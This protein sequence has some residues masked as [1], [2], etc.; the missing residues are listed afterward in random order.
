MAIVKF[1]NRPFS[2]FFPSAV[3]DFFINDMLPF[4]SA[5]TASMPATN[6]EE[7]ENEFNLEIAIPGLS[8]EDINVEIDNNRLVVSS[9]KEESS[10]EE[11]KNYTRKEYSFSSFERAFTLPENATGDVSAR[12]EDGVLIVTLPKKKVE[13]AKTKKVKVA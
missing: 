12:Y 13:I 6:I 2:P 10:E 8:K 4:R 11:D 7:T 3:D 5:N 1:R 9:E